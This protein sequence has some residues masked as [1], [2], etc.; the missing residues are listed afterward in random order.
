MDSGGRLM[1]IKL[2]GAAV[3]E[4]A[5]TAIFQSMTEEA[6]ETV[7]KQAVQSLLTPEKNHR[8]SGFGKSPLQQAF[9]QAIQAAAFKAVHD[10]IAN[11]PNLQIAIDKLMG[12]LILGAVKEGAVRYDDSLSE[13]IGRAVGSWIAEKSRGE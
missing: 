9:E 4:I 10:Q 8:M 13:A 2:D 6:R 5:S 12:P 11:D 1:E 3:A 7:L